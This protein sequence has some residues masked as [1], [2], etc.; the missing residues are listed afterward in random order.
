MLWGHISLK[1][2]T[3]K[4]NTVLERGCLAEAEGRLFL[5]GGEGEENV[6]LISVL[7]FVRFSTI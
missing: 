5:L 4:K 6:F 2:G 7:L 3:E 1:R